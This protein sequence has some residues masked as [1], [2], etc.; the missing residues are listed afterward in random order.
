VTQ[1]MCGV[2]AWLDA[3]K[4][5]VKLVPIAPVSR[6]MTIPVRFGPRSLDFQSDPQ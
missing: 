1:V 2:V 3:R 6:L 4:A 5:L